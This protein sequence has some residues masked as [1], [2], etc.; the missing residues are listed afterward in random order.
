MYEITA[1]GHFD[2]AHF[3]RGYPGKCANIHGHR[4]QVDIALQGEKLDEMGILIDFMDV[5]TML[6]E[7]LEV[8]DHKL[9]NDIQPF[10]ALNPTAENI[11]RFIYEQMADKLKN[12]T[13][14]RVRSTRVTVW[15]S[16]NTSA[17]YFCD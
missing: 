12:Q 16:D 7:V 8:F 5:K 14:E 3:L 9:I 13:G 17:T 15:E 2:S 1:S 4:W 11:A 10:D 6:K